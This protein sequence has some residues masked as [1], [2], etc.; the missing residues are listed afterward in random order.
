MYDTIEIENTLKLMNKYIFDF[1]L[2]NLYRTGN[3]NLSS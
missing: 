2:I 1:A 3:V